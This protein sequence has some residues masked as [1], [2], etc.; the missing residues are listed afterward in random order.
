MLEVAY[1]CN[2]VNSLSFSKAPSAKISPFEMRFNADLL[3]LCGREGNYLL[4]RKSNC[5]PYNTTIRFDW[6]LKEVLLN[7]PPS[8]F[9]FRCRLQR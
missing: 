6:V 9:S 8:Q 7:E 4:Y 1:V 3:F 2:E 5:E